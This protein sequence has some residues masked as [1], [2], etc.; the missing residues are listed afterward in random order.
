MTVETYSNIQYQYNRLR[1]SKE[2]LE[3]NA[4]IV[5]QTQRPPHIF[6]WNWFRTWPT[7]EQGLLL[8]TLMQALPDLWEPLL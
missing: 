8:L 3:R 1:W 2:D 4:E 7:E 5:F 6:F